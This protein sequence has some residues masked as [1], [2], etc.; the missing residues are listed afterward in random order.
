MIKEIPHTNA[1]VDFSFAITWFQYQLW[2]QPKVSANLGFDFGIR[3][4]S[5][6]CVQSWSYVLLI[7]FQGFCFVRNKKASQFLS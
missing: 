7:G 4:K 1:L 5:K 2:Y 3:S 6:Q